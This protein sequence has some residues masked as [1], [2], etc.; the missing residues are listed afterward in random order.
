MPVLLT[1]LFLLLAHHT[2]AN[3]N[4]KPG[5]NP[6]MVWMVSDPLTDSAAASCRGRY[7]P[8]CLEL[9]QSMALSCRGRYRPYCLQMM[10]EIE[11]CRGR[12][13]PYCLE[14]VSNVAPA[15]A[16]DTDPTVWRWWARWAQPAE[17]TISLTVSTS[18]PRWLQSA[19]DGSGHTAWRKRW[20]R[21][22]QAQWHWHCN[23]LENN[24]MPDHRC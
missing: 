3:P 8:Y 5:P 16:E 6:Q 23:I 22:S 7:R 2:H 20:P 17:E 4:P 15:C 21:C 1:L 10:S 9:M 19:V 12:Y 11:L 13:R 24:A 14:M 18:F